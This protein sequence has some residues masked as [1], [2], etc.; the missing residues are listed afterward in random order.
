M[1]RHTRATMVV[2]YFLSCFVISLTGQLRP[3]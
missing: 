1:S 3:M 2:N